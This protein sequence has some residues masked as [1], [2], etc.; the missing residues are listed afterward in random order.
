MRRKKNILLTGASGSIGIYIL[1]ELLNR[2]EKFNLKVFARGSHKN[3]KL[4]K[5]YSTEIDIVW[6]DIT[7][8]EKCRKAVKEQD[9]IIHA[10]AIIPPKAYKKPDDTKEVNIGG[11]KN[12]ID[13][14]K[15]FDSEAKIIY[16]SSIVVYG[17]RLDNPIITNRDKP[18]PND[19][20]GKTKVEAEN[21]IKNSGLEYIIFRLS[22]VATVDKLRF[23]P[24]MFK[25]PLKTPIEI[26][27]PEDVALAIGNSIEKENLWNHT[28]NLGG[29]ENCRKIF[30][31]YL[32]D[33]LEIM[34]IGRN[35]F[36]E[37]AFAKKGFNCGYFSNSSDLQD[38]LNFQTKDL[39]DFYQKVRDWIGVKRI[40]A[41]IFRW[42]IKKYLLRYS[43]FYKKYKDK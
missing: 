38:L 19:I 41:R 1:K 35:Y 21:I 37:E 18:N 26:I 24:I 17:D 22:Y 10:A 31:E 16:T 11:T 15:S 29:G 3:R 13:A 30:K 6:G 25:M 2:K 42:F 43:K 12:I 40:F 9:I 32:N 28:Y 7:D 14:L 34:G 36:P 23:N 20:Y 27:H 33:I 8:I 5:S 4:F 39:E